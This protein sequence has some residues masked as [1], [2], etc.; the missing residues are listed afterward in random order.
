MKYEKCLSCNQLGANCDGPNL[1]MLDGVELGQWMNELRKRRPGMTYDRTSAGAG[2]SKTAVY[3]FLTG[4]HPDCRLDT[5]RPVAKLL[6]GGDCDDNPCGNVSNSEKAAYEERIHQYEA[7]IAWRNDKI[8]HLSDNYNSLTTLVA[9]TNKR[10]DETKQSYENELAF[11]RKEIKR[12]NKF[13]TAMTIL[14][15]LAA[16]YIIAM[17]IIDR[18]DPSKGYF[19]IESLFKPHSINEFLQQWRT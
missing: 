5:V 8:Q 4:T 17:L 16:L 6:I 3:N 9:N 19:W 11:L 2:V 1:L 13:M 7:E 14:F 12:K 10:H 15:V 18:L